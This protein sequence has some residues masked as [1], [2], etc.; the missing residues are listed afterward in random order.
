MRAVICTL[1]ASAA[2]AGADALRLVVDAHEER[3]SELALG[4]N[5]LVVRLELV[6]DVLFLYDS[7]NAHHL[8]NLVA[9][10][11]SIFE[12]EC[13]V[14]ADD[15]TTYRLRAKRGS[16]DCVGE[17]VGRADSVTVVEVCRG[18]ETRLQQHTCPKRA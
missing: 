7:F 5:Q 18:R 8:L 10:R 4:V 6:K 16:A 14:V 9:D 11:L 2:L 3:A 17:G 15:D 13:E 1:A 12:Q